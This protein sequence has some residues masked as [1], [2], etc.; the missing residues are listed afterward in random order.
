[1]HDS[2]DLNSIRVRTIKHEDSLEAGYPEDSQSS[3]FGML[4]PGMP[5]HLRICGQQAKCLMRR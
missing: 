1:M 4:E 2:K 5:S 3:E